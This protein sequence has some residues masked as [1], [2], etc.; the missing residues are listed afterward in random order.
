MSNITIEEWQKLPPIKMPW[1][2]EKFTLTEVKGLCESCGSEL[3]DVRGEIY[4][5]F[6]VV[7]M[8]M[9]GVCLHCRGLVN[10]RSRVYPDKH[11]FSQERNGRWENCNMITKNR[12]WFRESLKTFMPMIMGMSFVVVLTMATTKPTH[13][14]FFWWSV[15]LVCFIALSTFVG[16]M[17]SR[18]K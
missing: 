9:A 18:R 4:E 11:L 8:R 10:L 5:A 13:W 2:G 6:G 14:T 7:E 16:W 17:M 15:I 3:K 12:I 1:V